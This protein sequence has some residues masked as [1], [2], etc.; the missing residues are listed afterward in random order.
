MDIPIKL[1]L[2]IFGQL[3]PPDVLNLAA[4]CRKLYNSWQQHTITIYNLITHTE[5]D[6]RGLADQ[7]ILQ[8]DSAMTV[9]GFLQLRR[10]AQVM[11]KIVERYGREFVILYCCPMGMRLLH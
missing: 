8:I 10:N 2:Y 4:T 7:G 5:P 3:P 11:E 1:I 6:A 9:T